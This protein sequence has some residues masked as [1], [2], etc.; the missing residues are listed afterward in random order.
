[1]IDFRLIGSPNVGPHWLLFLRHSTLGLKI[2]RV[3]SLWT[4]V[5]DQELVR[6]LLCT[7]L[8]HER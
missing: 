5:R 8:L 4:R 2:L 6:D 3:S 1:M 7:E